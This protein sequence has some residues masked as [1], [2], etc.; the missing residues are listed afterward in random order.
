MPS[1]QD[2]I[3]NGLTFV[4]LLTVIAV[5]TASL[6]PEVS[7]KPSELTSPD[8][9]M[10]EAMPLDTLEELPMI[11]ERPLVEEHPKDTFATDTMLTVEPS[12]PDSSLHHHEEHR[13]E[14]SDAPSSSSVTSPAKMIEGHGVEN[15]T[16]PSKVQEEKSLM[17]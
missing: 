2:K 7:A 12:S 11:E 14:E 17:E 15:T 5:G 16:V 6:W 10:T 1:L 4:G 8:E 3:C 9:P 13:A